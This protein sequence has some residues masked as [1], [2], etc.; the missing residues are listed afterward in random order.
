MH[1]EGGLCA[2]QTLPQ[3]C[4]PRDYYGWPHEIA[5]PARSRDLSGGILCFRDLLAEQRAAAAALMAIA[6][7][8]PQARLWECRLG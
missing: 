6:A 8:E 5:Q 1:R 3:F 7:E 4:A 2:L